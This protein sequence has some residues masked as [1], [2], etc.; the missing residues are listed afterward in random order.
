MA[1]A[2]WAAEDE[3]TLARAEEEL[4]TWPGSLVSPF[5]P[6]ASPRQHPPTRPW[7]PARRPRSGGSLKTCWLLLRMELCGDAWTGG[8]VPSQEGTGGHGP[9]DTLC[10]A[11][12]RAAAGILLRAEKE[13][14]GLSPAKTGAAGSGP[15]LC[16]A[17]GRLLRGH[18]GTPGLCGDTGWWWKGG[19]GRGRHV[20]LGQE[21]G[22]QIPRGAGGVGEHQE[23]MP[24]TK[25][26]HG[27]ER[28]PTKQVPGCPYPLR[29]CW[30]GEGA[31]TGVELRGSCQ[32]GVCRVA[33]AAILEGLLAQRLCRRQPRPGHP[34]G[35]VSC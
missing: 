23:I 34:R 25:S 9:P 12:T 7:P 35:Q 5:E 24:G 32:L 30:E 26:Q 21:D 20:V 22:T 28:S 1:R 4:K 14:Q 13:P 2:T 31:L 33:P 3:E 16:G 17:C 11:S 6:I 8:L 18:L 27:L 29:C 19:L 10:L 15:Q